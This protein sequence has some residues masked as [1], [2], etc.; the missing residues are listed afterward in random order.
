MA[1]KQFGQAYFGGQFGFLELL[2]N[3][4]E[5]DTVVPNMVNINS[6]SAVVID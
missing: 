4:L 2:T 1:I 6:A 3:Q 5:V